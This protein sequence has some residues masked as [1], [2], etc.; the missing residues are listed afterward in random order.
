MDGYYSHPSL[1]LI[2]LKF[3]FM[4]DVLIYIIGPPAFSDHNSAYKSYA[5][6]I[7]CSNSDPT[8][9]KSTYR[10]SNGSLKWDRVFATSIRKH[11]PEPLSIS[12]RFH[13]PR[14]GTP[15]AEVLGHDWKLKKIIKF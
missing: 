5:D 9:F 7:R 11:R 12:P 2:T 10:V 14:P 4:F 3:H 13:C 15:L 1:N 6:I 8:L